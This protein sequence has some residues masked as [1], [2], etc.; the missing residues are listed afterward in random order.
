MA[1]RFDRVTIPTRPR[2]TDLEREVE[3][4]LDRSDLVQVPPTERTDDTARELPVRALGGAMFTWLSLV[5]VTCYLVFPIVLAATGVTHGILAAAPFSLPAF[6]LA[7]F[8][9]I[10]AAQIASP[11]IKLDVRASRDP[12]LSATLGGLGVWAVVHNSSAL[13]EPFWAMG[14]TEFASFFALNVLEMT[15]LGMMFASFTQRRSVALALG[16]G[17]Q[18]LVLGIV[19]TLMSIAVM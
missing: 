13:L 1:T 2:A 17:F 11:K 7:S 3:A 15:M 4:L 14:P 6:A 12:V 18:L 9:S 16:G 8:V 5:F 10:V 19:L